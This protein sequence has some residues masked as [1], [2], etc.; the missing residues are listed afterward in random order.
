[1]GASFPNDAKHVEYLVA[2]RC[3]ALGRWRVA[4][5]TYVFGV[6]EPTSADTGIKSTLGRGCLLAYGT[7]RHHDLSVR[8]GR[9]KRNDPA[10]LRLGVDHESRVGQRIRERF[11][12][13]GK[14]RG[15][16]EEECQPG[17]D[18]QERD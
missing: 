15:R 4:G 13:V 2:V 18:E 17:D 7:N 9:Y 6:G 10:L 14:D 5:A 8:T 11:V 16:P 1:M 3:Q 12:A